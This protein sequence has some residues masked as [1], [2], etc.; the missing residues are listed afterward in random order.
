MIARKPGHY[1]VRIGTGPE[2]IAFWSGFDWLIPGR[3]SSRADADFA[4]IDERR[5]ERDGETN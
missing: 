4:Q 2:F 5:I 1:W 3:M